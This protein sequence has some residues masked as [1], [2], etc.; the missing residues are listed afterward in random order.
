MDGEPPGAPDAV[1]YKGR[2]VWWCVWW[3]FSPLLPF[4][5][6]AAVLGGG[7]DLPRGPGRIIWREGG[8]VPLEF[9]AHGNQVHFEEAFLDP[10]S[11]A[12]VLALV[13]S[14]DGML[15]AWDRGKI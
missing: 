11:G 3:L 1:G 4:L 8:R 13:R 15:N 6:V 2:I 12:A 5:F 9:K 7:G 10:R 14:F